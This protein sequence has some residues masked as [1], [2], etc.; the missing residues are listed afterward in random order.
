MQLGRLPSALS[1]LSLGTQALD[2]LPPAAH[3]PSLSLDLSLVGTGLL[4]GRR[5]ATITIVL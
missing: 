3:S 4:G 2:L 1:E 5:K